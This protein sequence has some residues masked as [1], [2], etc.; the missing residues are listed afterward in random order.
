MT[1]CS[2][3]LLDLCLPLLPL[4]VQPE[5]HTEL[6]IINQ[7]LQLRTMADRLVPFRPHHP[8]ECPRFS[9]AFVSAD[10]SASP[11][12]M[13]HSFLGDPPCIL[14]AHIPYLVKLQ[15]VLGLPNTFP[16]DL[17]C[18]RRKI[19]ASLLHIGHPQYGLANNRRESL[20][21]ICGHH[22]HPIGD[23]PAGPHLPVVDPALLRPLDLGILFLQIRKEVCCG[24]RGLSIQH[25]GI[26]K[27]KGACAHRRQEL[28]F[29]SS[30]SNEITFCL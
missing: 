12:E 30:G 2:H 28:D 16:Y 21:Y 29:I 27:C 26:S 25:A 9:L 15:V 6:P 23:R 18:L 8:G 17:V 7:A 19:R 3:E 5:Q 4:A 22:I 1:L 10:S 11:G 20:R 14:F 13:T 24:C